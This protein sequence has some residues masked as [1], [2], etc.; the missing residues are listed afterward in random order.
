MHLAIKKKP[1]IMENSPSPSSRMV[2]PPTTK[3]ESATSVS[4]CPAVGEGAGPRHCGMDLGG[5]RGGGKGGE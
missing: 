5:G 2:K 1:F 3:R 4:V